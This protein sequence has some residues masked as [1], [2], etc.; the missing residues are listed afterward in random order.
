M[1]IS[2]WAKI[3]VE[4]LQ[5]DSVAQPMEEERFCPPTENSSNDILDLDNI[6]NATDSLIARDRGTGANYNM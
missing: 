4:E 5:V 3:P 1:E 6:C 2:E